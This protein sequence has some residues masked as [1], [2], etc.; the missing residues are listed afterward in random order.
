MAAHAQLKFLRE[1]SL[2]EGTRFHVLW[3]GQKASNG[4][5][6]EADSPGDPVDE[7]TPL[8]PQPLTI[9]P[10]GKAGDGLDED[11]WGI[12]GHPS[13]PYTSGYG[14]GDGIDG[15]GEDGYYNDY[16]TW[17]TDRVLPWLRD[18]A[19]KFAVRF[20]DKFG[21]KQTDGLVQVSVD[22]RGDPRPPTQFE[23]AGWDDVDG[24][25]DLAWRHTP[26]LE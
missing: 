9:W 7:T 17:K 3:N 24:E 22:V 15:D 2:P 14:D 4:D 6:A 19:Y 23:F 12:D 11:G 10:S 8:T 16:L 21:T 18:G 5:G 1:N 26:D 20:E 25:I 13:N